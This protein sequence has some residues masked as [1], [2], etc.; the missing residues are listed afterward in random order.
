M[1]DITIRE[2]LEKDFKEVKEM[3]KKSFENA[4]HTDNNEHNLVEKLR[5]SDNF[6]KE[7]SLV[8]EKKGKIIGH[9]MSTRLDIVSNN[10]NHIALAIAPLSVHPDFQKNGVGSSLMKE[11]IKIAKELGYD[12]IFVLGSDK[13]YPRFGFKKSTDFGISAP[14]EVPSENFMA[15]ELTKGALENISGNIVYAKE[16]FEE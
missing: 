16:F 1:I 12:S 5:K 6:I 2:E 7:L 8:A 14:F 13:Y 9:I 11:T 4:E 10:K 15:I 3:I